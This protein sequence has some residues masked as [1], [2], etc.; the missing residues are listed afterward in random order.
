MSV[1][2]DLGYKRYLG[3]RRSAA[4][5]WTVIMRDQIASGRKKWWRYWLPLGMAVITL[6]IAGG[7][8]YFSQDK[9][10]SAIG[11]KNGNDLMIKMADAVIPLSFKFFCTAAFVLSLTLGSTII[12]SDTQSGAFTFYFVRSIRPRDYMLGKLTG[13]GFLVAIIVLVC[14]LV[15]V[16]FRLGMCHTTDELVERLDLIPKILALGTL[17]TLLYTTMPLAMSAILPNR[18]MALGLW[19]A[20][21]IIVGGIFTAI[22]MASHTPIGALDLQYGLQS[23]T[24]ELFDIQLIKGRG[25]FLEMMPLV[26]TLVVIGI[27][28][29]VGMGVV[30]FQV[31]RDQRTG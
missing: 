23:V 31:S 15:L 1:I 17:A 18:R 19:A 30:W 5:R 11:G 14:P 29:I 16:A 27:Q 25:P 28:V 20:Y 22:G 21:Y 3:T 9:I 7:L 6:C 10:V 4:T 13:Y 24:F 2:H 8:M 12:A 26:G